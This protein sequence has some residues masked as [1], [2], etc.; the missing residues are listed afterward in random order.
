MEKTDGSI[1]SLEEGVN[2][3]QMLFTYSENEK[4]EQRIN[5]MNA[6][7][8]LKP[9]FITVDYAMLHSGYS[10]LETALYGFISYFLTNNEKFYCTNEQLAEMLCV[11]ENTITNAMNR[12]KKDELINLTYKTKANGWKIRFVR[13][14]KFGFPNHKICVSE[15]QNLWGIY[16]KK[17]ENKKIEYNINDFSELYKNYY[18]LNKWINEKVCNKLINLKL[19]Q[20][21]TLEQIKVGLVLYNTEF[22]VKGTDYKYVKKFETW[23]KEF[24][25]LTEEQIEENLTR[26]IRLHKERKKS[27]AKY[28]QSLPS[29]KARADLCEA[30]WTEKVNS[31]FKSEDTSNT[32]LHFT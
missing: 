7:L 29:K 27:D 24:Q 17:I 15:P 19:M 2:V 28:W 14:T 4:E 25:P 10:L 26:I 8:I 18:W 31:I 13:L 9:Q 6:D 32:I 12:L 30:F 20:W 21:I 11:S 5:K 1:T 16:N 23:I 22:R 3:E